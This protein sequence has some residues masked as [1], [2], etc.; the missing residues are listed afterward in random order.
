[1]R[2][3]AI[4]SGIAICS[5]ASAADY[6]PGFVWDRS[7]DWN[8]GKEKGYAWQN[9]NPDDDKQDSPVWVCEW[10]KGGGGLG[11]NDAWYKQ[12]KTLMTWDDNW[13]NAGY[14]TWSNGNDNHPN[15]TKGGLTHVVYPNNFDDAPIVRWMN[16][17]GTAA[18]V[19]ISGNVK[20]NWSGQG[21]LDVALVCEVAVVVQTGNQYDV[22]FGNAYTDPSPG[23]QEIGTRT[24]QVSLQDVVVP[25]G[26]SILLGIRGQ[27]P[28]NNRWFSSEDNLKI[29]L[30]ALEGGGGCTADIDGNGVL[31]L[32]DFLGFVNLF[33]AGC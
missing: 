26:G 19:T 20:V 23:D 24:I 9:G 22:I 31:D 32:F 29:T 17:T 10:A 6:F 18:T 28:Q 21:N 25:E 11:D 13:Y 12:P 4:A 8:D 30:V 15:I 5:V 14:P 27:T 16:P 33:N 7:L 1:M 2:H 3:I